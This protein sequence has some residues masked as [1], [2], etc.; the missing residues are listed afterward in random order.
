M[1]YPSVL[2]VYL[3]SWCICCPQ[4]ISQAKYS[5]NP[6]TVLC[7]TLC[8]VVLRT[9]RYTWIYSLN[10]VLY[11]L[12]FY[13]LATKEPWLITLECYTQLSLFL[14]LYSP[15][16][17]TVS[18]IPLPDNLTTSCIAWCAYYVIKVLNPKLLVLF[19]YILDNQFQPSGKFSSCH[20]FM[21]KEK[22]FRNFQQC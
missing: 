5:S 4:S 7:S 1:G 6:T 15:V 13:Y 9:V 22:A 8:T 19:V 10:V 18:L 11:L 20:N 21:L 16:N 2:T 17:T 12:T 14:S 3:V